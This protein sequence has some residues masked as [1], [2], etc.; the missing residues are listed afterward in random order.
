MAGS[1]LPWDPVSALSAADRECFAE[2]WDDLC[3][4]NVPGPFYAGE[5]DTCWTGRL[6]A[7][8][9][10]MYGGEYLSEYVFRQPRDAAEV[11]GI[12]E[13]AW[14]DPFRGYGCNGDEHWM[15]ESVRAWWRARA[16]VTGSVR[17]SLKVLESEDRGESREAAQ[18]ARD[19]LAYID[20]G[21]EHD[22]R[23]YLF[24]LETGRYPVRGE[25]LPEI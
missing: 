12:V 3:E 20:G 21:L 13:A 24:R 10:V 5:T 11:A 25:S 2:R 14:Q 23:R 22:L 1:E 4:L 9:N 8:G 18:G 15:P 17:D 7:P 16:R 19:F 6:H